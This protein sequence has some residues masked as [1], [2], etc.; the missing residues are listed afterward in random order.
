[1]IRGGTELPYAPESCHISAEIWPHA[2]EPPNTAAFGP[3]QIAGSQSDYN[4][5]HGTHGNVGMHHSCNSMEP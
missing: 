1:M 2:D 4:P 3:K 5:R